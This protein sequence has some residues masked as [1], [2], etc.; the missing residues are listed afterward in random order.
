MPILTI[1]FDPKE[2][3]SIS[4]QYEYSHDRYKEFQG[5]VALT[6]LQLAQEIKENPALKE[7]L[8]RCLLVAENI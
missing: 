1:Y 6:E 5:K 7:S 4:A 8:K 2:V 3:S